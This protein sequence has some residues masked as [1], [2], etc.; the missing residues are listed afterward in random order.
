MSA[1][2]PA[3]ALTQPRYF[4]VIV[5]LA[6]PSLAV[7]YFS[8][9]F[10][11]VLVCFP[12]SFPGL[13]ARSW[14]SGRLAPA[15]MVFT[16]LFDIGLYLRVAHVRSEKP[17]I[18]AASCLGCSPV[19]VVTA[20]HFLLQTAIAYTLS[21]YDWNVQAR[22]VEEILAHTYFTLVSAV[23]LPFLVIRLMQQFNTR[24]S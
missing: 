7:A 1:P 8:V 6:D 18:L 2:A 19:I 20:L 5:R 11:A 14:S 17:A 21:A 22:V 9:V 4:R 15:M 23:F 13:I 24:N 3:L 12:V 16:V 10:A